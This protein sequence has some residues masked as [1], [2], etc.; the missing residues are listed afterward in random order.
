[1]AK[2]P[3]IW[4][5]RDGSSTITQSSGDLLLETGGYLLL[6]TGGFI[7]LEA[8]TVTQKEDTQ[9]DSPLSRLPAQWVTTGYATLAPSNSGAQ[10]AEQDGTIRIEQDGTIR[11][12]QETVV[13]PKQP[14]QWDSL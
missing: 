12:L 7:Q 9:W 1:M 2:L 14:S 13:T 11:V 6:E 5:T 4:S 3:A 10:R 8:V